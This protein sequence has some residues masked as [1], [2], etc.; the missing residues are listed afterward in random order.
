VHTGDKPFACDNCEKRFADR[1]LYLKHCRTHANT[2]TRFGCS[3]CPKTFMVESNLMKHAK[4]HASEAYS[5]SSCGKTFYDQL[6]LT[7]HFN[8]HQGE[9]PF[10]CDA[11]GKQ[12][13]RLG[14]SFCPRCVLVTC[15]MYVAQ[16]L[17]AFCYLL[18][19][20][21]RFALYAEVHY[22]YRNPPDR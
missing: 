4:V 17:F 6:T 21:Q 10:K 8:L 13:G 7:A 3:L 2:S 16:Y 22:L 18:L 9:M 15:D 14:E 19:F 12:F 5:C 11:C 20:S 1:S